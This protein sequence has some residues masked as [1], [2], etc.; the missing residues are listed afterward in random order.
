IY[1]Q[2]RENEDALLRSFSALTL[3]IKELK[4][5]RGRRPD[6]MDRHL[7][8]SARTLRIHNVT[9]GSW[10]SA[11]QGFGQLFQLATMG[12]IL[13]VIAAALQLPGDVMISYL[14]V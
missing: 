13:F 4:L 1:H 6:F 5:H 14:L 12:L 10:F 9:A 2:A 7:L 3:G 11:A 8:G